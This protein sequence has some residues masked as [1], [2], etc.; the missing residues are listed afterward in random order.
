M[1]TPYKHYFLHRVRTPFERSPAIERFS[2]AAQEPVPIIQYEK[3][4]KCIQ[5]LECN[6]IDVRSKEEVE[7]SGAIPTSVNIP[8]KDIESSFS[9]P[10]EKFTNM[11][12]IPKPGFTDLIICH[13][14]VGKR[15]IKACSLLMA[16]GYRNV[17]N[18]A[19]GWKNWKENTNNAEKR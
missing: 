15:S 11:Y 8:L 14:Y 4:V 13:C 2:T 5:A 19:G 18:Y 3:L 16:M 7:R 9:L 6:V 1:S 10:D 12:Q 17:M